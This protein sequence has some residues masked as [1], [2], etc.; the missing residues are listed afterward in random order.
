MLFLFLL[1]LFVIFGFFSLISWLISYA[2]FEFAWWSSWRR[3]LRFGWLGV[4]FSIV[5]V[6]AILVGF[7][8]QPYARAIIYALP[9][10]TQTEQTQPTNGWSGDE[11]GP[12]IAF[13]GAANGPAIAETY[14]PNTGFCAL[15]KVNV[16]ETLVWDFPG[17]WWQALAGQR[18]LDA[19]W[20]HHTE[21]YLAKS[22]T[23]HCVVYDSVEEFLAA[24]PTYR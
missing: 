17:A 8:M 11:F 1:V 24:N 23:S 21:E 3:G 13:P 9:T 15:I 18:S 22:K 19:R 4:L 6:C 7:A 2:A 20:G 5:M 16:R 14:N 12:E 10:G